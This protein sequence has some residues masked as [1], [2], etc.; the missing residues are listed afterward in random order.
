VER[1]VR[2]D[3]VD[4]YYGPLVENF[5]LSNPKYRVPVEV[6][7]NNALFHV[8]VEDDNVASTLIMRLSQE[9]LGRLTFMPLKQ[10][11]VQDMNYPQSSDVHPLMSVA[12][13]YDQ[14]VQKAMQQ[15]FGKKLIA[16]DFSIATKFARECNM[17]AITME[18]DEVNRKGALEGG[19]HD[20]RRSRLLSFAG[21]Q[22]SRANLEKCVQKQQE[23]RVKNLEVDSAVTSLMGSIQRDEAKKANLK[24]TGAQTAQD[25]RH[26]TDDEALLLE[27]LEKMRTETLPSVTAELKSME[28]QAD[29]YRA[30]LGSEL[31]QVLSPQEQAELQRLKDSS[32]D[33]EMAVEKY[34]Q[35]A[36]NAAVGRSRLNTL[37]KVN[38]FLRS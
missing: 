26:F 20:E 30:E 10:L 11:Q 14:K 6:A 7:A 22:E 16:R 21:I 34:G 27:K 36:E 2:E 15:V 31:K 37:L 19:F 3:K 33:L 23:V 29:A 8:I 25:L 35:V 9:N 17:D 5:E 13:R 28:A 4:G 1:I 24:N 12:I 18:G 32:A 38:W